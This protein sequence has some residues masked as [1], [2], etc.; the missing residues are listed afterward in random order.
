M[1]S[2]MLMSRPKRII[3]LLYNEINLQAHMYSMWFK[4]WLGFIKST[5][6][7][8]ADCIYNLEVS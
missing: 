2:F 7:Y 5:N 4:L 6:S 8:I 3:K 1:K